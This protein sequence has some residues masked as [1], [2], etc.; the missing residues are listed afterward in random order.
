MS[1]DNKPLKRIQALQP[2][3]RDHHHGLLL[4][5]KIRSG[6]KKGVEIDRIKKYTDWFWENHLEQ[7]FEVEE[8]Y[9][10]PVL[11]DGNELVRKALTQHRRLSRLFQASTELEKNL[12]LIEEEL[13]AHIRFEERV[14]FNEIQQLASPEQLRIMEE[15][16]YSPFV[17]NLDDE[18]W[19]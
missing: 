14:V 8:R 4:C 3:S 19:K 6:F 16:D 9:L 11:G 5:W 18:F 12:S 10:F 15:H 17:D 13:N 1:L 2:I 7:H